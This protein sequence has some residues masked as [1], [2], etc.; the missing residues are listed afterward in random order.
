MPHEIGWFNEKNGLRLRKEFMPQEKTGQ[1]AFREE[2]SAFGRNHA[3]LTI[4][5][6]QMDFVFT[7]Y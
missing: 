4:R 7:G 6:L 3:V 2:S 1:C 5:K